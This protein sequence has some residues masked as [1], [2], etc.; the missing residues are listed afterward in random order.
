[1]LLLVASLVHSAWRWVW[2]RHAVQ[3]QSS[4]LRSG[5]RRYRG[6]RDRVTVKEGDARK[7]PFADSTFDVVVSN[8]VVHELKSR[9]D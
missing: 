4:G 7:L 6:V 1:M 8:F 9:A 5:K 2:N 3:R